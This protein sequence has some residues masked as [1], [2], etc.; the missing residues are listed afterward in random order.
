M[1]SKHCNTDGRSLWNASGTSFKNKPRLVRFHEST[2]VSLWTFQLTF[3]CVCY[4]IAEWFFFILSF[5]V[6]YS[7]WFGLVRLTTIRLSTRAGAQIECKCSHSCAEEVAII[8]VII[9]TPD[10]KWLGCEW[11]HAWKRWAENFGNFLK[12]V[13]SWDLTLDEASRF[14]KWGVARPVWAYGMRCAF[15]G[16]D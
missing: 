4:I 7:L 14:L 10:R 6:G 12:K 11:R 2:L 16:S 15:V 3:V 9:K 5:F 8:K 13:L 1:E